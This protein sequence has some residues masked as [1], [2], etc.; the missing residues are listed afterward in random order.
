M[1]KDEIFE[2]F[3]K[4]LTEELDASYALR[5]RLFDEERDDYDF[6][7]ADVYITYGATRGAIIEENYDWIAKF[8]ISEDSRVQDLCER[9]E[10][11]YNKAAKDKI[12]QCFAQS[13][14]LGDFVYT[15]TG[16]DIYQVCDDLDYSQ[17]Y[18]RA[19]E[20][21]LSEKYGTCENTIRL[22]LYAYPKAVTGKSFTASAQSVEKVKEKNR[23]PLTERYD[24]IGAMFLEQYGDEVYEALCQF[25]I[26]EDINDIHYGNIGFID[27]K[28]VLIDYAGYHSGDTEPSYEEEDNTDYENY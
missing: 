12:N 2:H 13:L 4:L 16:T 20:K 28:I 22:S 6:D 5:R 9:E 27:N 19:A 25:C 10:E 14:Y 8:S 15:W 11:L 1:E 18:S 23:S 24:K 7:T 17:E 3:S 26:W 21:T